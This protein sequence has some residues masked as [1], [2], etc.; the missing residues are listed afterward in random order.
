MTKRF[1][2]L[3]CAAALLPAALP[4]APAFDISRV[5]RDV[6]VLSSDAYQGRAPA[7]PAETKTV[8]YLIAQMQAAGLRPGG[9]GGW[10]Q[11]VP[12]LNGHLDGEKV[13]AL[14]G[15]MVPVA[16]SSSPTITVPRR[17]SPCTSR[18]STGA[19]RCSRSQRIAHSNTGLGVPPAWWTCA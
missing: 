15:T 13:R 2:L 5:S 3:A 11:D 17:K 16:S 1:T 6:Q 4:A 9:S 12:L 7:T 18:G 10:T 14:L 8:A 19:G